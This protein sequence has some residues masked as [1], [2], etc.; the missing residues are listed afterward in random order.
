[1]RQTLFKIFHRQ[2]ELVISWIVVCGLEAID[3]TRIQL[4]KVQ[5]IKNQKGWNSQLIP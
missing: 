5:F 4:N 1:M 3:V 2:D